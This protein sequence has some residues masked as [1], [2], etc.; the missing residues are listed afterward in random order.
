[1]DASRDDDDPDE[2]H[3]IAEE[4][5]P[6]D[7][8]D[9]GDEFDELDRERLREKMM[10]SGRKFVRFLDMLGGMTD[11]EAM[12]MLREDMRVTAAR[13][14]RRGRPERPERPASPDSATGP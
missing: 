12:A 11:A 5:E 2:G 14:A 10:R 4:P 8:D 3:A 9:D 6:P 7:E 1:M 13:N